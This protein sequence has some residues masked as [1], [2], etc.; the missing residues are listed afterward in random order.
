MRENPKVA[1]VVDALPGMGGAEK[2]LMASMELFPAAPIYTMMYHRQAF[3]GTPLASR[4]VL[5]SFIDR[6][7]FIQTQY[8]KY[9]AMMPKTIE[10]FDLS[11]FDVILSFSYA[12][13]NGVRTKPGQLHLSYTH[14]P[15]RYAWRGIHPD[16][17]RRPVSPPV[18]MIFKSF[19]A[20]DSAAAARVD[21][22]ATVS[23]W[24]Q[25]CIQQVYRRD[26]QVIYPPVDIER[27]RPL[28]VRE[29]YYVAL[30]R[31]VP[32][33]R[34]DLI[35]ESFK[36]IKL[37]LVVIG[38]GPEFK[39]LSQEA[40]PNIQ[41]LGS[42][43]DETV[44]KLLDQAR[45]LICATEEDFGIAMVEAQAA[46]CPVIAYAKGGALETVKEY[47][48]GLFFSEQTPES[49]IDAVE[50][51][52]QIACTFDLQQLI[53]NARRFSKQRFQQELLAFISNAT[54]IRV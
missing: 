32:H 44:E 45:G 53:S 26:A 11:G 48:T 25:E 15:M 24:I 34:I 30:S 10:R 8:R 6:L 41:F 2:V 1:F 51:F 54:S 46:G 19:R 47:Q 16:G 14:T 43:D 31:L 22:F 37:P 52:E 7:P 33:K 42:Q 28:P 29:K 38:L 18:N 4:R 39:R 5:T 50:R 17:T 13:A 40:S 35:V 9:I 49:L 27:F 21:Q 36:R 3:A 20:W 23:C 12:V